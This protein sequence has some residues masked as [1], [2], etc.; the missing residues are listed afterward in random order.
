MILGFLTRP[1][2]AAWVTNRKQIG[3]GSDRET[4]DQAAVRTAGELAGM[5]RV[6]TL[7]DFQRGAL[8][9]NRK[10]FRV[11]CAAHMDRFGRQAKGVLAVAVL[12]REYRQ[13][14]ELF[15]CLARDVRRELKDKASLLLTG[16]ARLDVFEVRYVELCV[17]VELVY[18]CVKTVK[19]IKW[20]KGLHIFPYMVTEN[21]RQAVELEQVRRDSFA[22]PVFGEPEITLRVE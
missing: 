2:Q 9:A 7:E 16:E 11:K 3:G 18:N 1:A 21:G 4:I 13:G 22:V 15:A 14:S 5:G 19:H 10:I 12:P 6:V 20:I 8:R 17:S